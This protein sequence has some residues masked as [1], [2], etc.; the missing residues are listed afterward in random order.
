MLTAMPE[1]RQRAL[2]PRG[3]GRTA[4][5]RHLAT[6]AARHIFPIVKLPFVEVGFPVFLVDGGDAFGAVRIVGVGGRPDLR[7][8]V[9]GSGEHV[10]PYEAIEKVASKKVIVS[11]GRLGAEVQRA[12]A[13]A[14][15]LEDFPP[16]G[17]DEV[18][19]VPP[20][21]VD[22]DPQD[23]SWAPSFEGH[24]PLSP[25]DELPGRDVGSHYGVPPSIAGSHKPR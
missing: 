22:D 7:V 1:G 13:H 4:R 16:S 3:R 12:I 19:L 6:R 9:E 21:P 18:E 24:H 23:D 14:L 5:R 20:P 17:E 25:K 11:W 15:D 10:I 2:P 8:H